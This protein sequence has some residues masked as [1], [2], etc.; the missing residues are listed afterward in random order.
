MN[1][2]WSGYFFSLLISIIF[3]PVT[4][5]QQ[6]FHKLYSVKDGL[7]QSQAFSI[8]QDDDGYIWI[9]TVGGGVNIYD[10]QSFHTYTTED[11]LA[12]NIVYSIIK[13]RQGNLWFGTDQGISKY[14]G[15]I[16][17]NY[18]ESDGLP[19]KYVKCLYFAEDQTL[20]IGTDKGCARMNNGIITPIKINETIDNSIILSIVEDN[21]KNIFFG[22]NGKGIIKYSENNIKEYVFPDKLKNKVW[23]LLKSN[24]GHIIFGTSNG[25][26][27]IDKDSI[28]T[29]KSYPTIMNSYIDDENNLWFISWLG[30]I[31]KYKFEN[32]IY[33]S[34]NNIGFKNFHFR[35]VIKDIEGNF[36]LGSEEGL[37]KFPP[38]KFINYNESD[39]LHY[40]NVFSITQTDKNEFWVSASTNGVSKMTIDTNGNPSFINYK[41][42]HDEDNSISSSSVYSVTKDNQGRLWFGT[43]GGVSIYDPVNNK[44][45][46]FTDEETNN[47]NFIYTPG[48]TNKVVSNILIAKNNIIWIG[49][50]NGVTKFTDSVFVNFNDKFPELE[51]KDII[52]IFEDKQ[53]NIWFTTKEGIYKYKG[54]QLTHYGEKDGFIDDIVNTIVQDDDNIY[55]LST[56]NGIFR[57]DGKQ[58]ININ[59]SDGLS[60]NNI[61]LLG[62]SKNKIYIGTNKGLDVLNTES[63]NRN[64]KIDLKHFGDLEGFMG[65]ECNRNA[66]MEDSEG[67]LWFGT[68]GGV[69]IF[70]PEKDFINQVLPK[71]FIKSIK[72]NF[73]DFDWT[74][75]CD[76]IDYKTNLP[77]N[78]ELPY[79]KNHISFR[80]IATSLTIPEKV[81][82]KYMLEG[83][84]EEWSPALSKTEVD[85]PALPPGEY[86]FK[87]KACNNDDVWN[88][89][90]VMFAF[91]IKPPFWR[92]TWFYILVGLTSIILI[93]L[94][95]KRREAKLK[96][97]KMVLEEKVVERTAEIVR[98]KEIV[99]QK[100][101]DITD[102]IN[103][104]KNIQEAILPGIVEFQKQFP[105]SFI[106]YHPRDIVSGDFYWMSNKENRTF[107]AASDCTGHGVPGAFM[108]ILGIAFLDDIVDSNPKISAAAL[109]NQLREYVKLSLHQTGKDGEQKDGMDM[110]L[111]IIDWTNK[112]LQFAAANNPLYLIRENELIEYKGDKMPVGFHIRQDSF[113]N[114]FIKIQPDDKIYLFSDGYAD[115]FGG[116]DNKKFKYKK[117]KELILDIHTTPMN[118]QKAIF[119]KT[120]KDWMGENH[121]IDDILVMGICIQ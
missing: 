120:I 103:Y 95:V 118:Q 9:G 46:N 44:F 85:Y 2:S 23:T 24:A 10:G 69:T 72:L 57:F 88:E 38:I 98:Q 42:Q 20:Y 4:Y 16:F 52:Y 79:N 5:G 74:P 48:L 82:Y 35:S 89:T 15:K 40:N 14:D 34:T 55:W 70:D 56:K 104:A 109:L 27:Y 6:Y 61:Y 111:G 47:K 91:T 19:N 22:T 7:S 119:E 114:N 41:Y 63:Y 112:E 84:D 11:G 78:L 81:K 113:T 33:K 117:L 28:Y 59:K 94:F 105:S 45:S 67:R 90:P 26:Y 49:T 80:Y 76:S 12:G 99:E 8:L 75:F 107:F 100:N 102:S 92:T 18:Y 73:M 53:S 65:Q 29:I 64:K 58:F 51:N 86:I 115:Q 43:W 25:L 21:E 50:V 39:S 108:S 77:Y 17:T 30:W 106:F 66:F 13:D 87:V 83:L 110:V 1:P 31:Y 121:Q 101:K 93:Y 96:K 97:E 116:A 54:K 37:I 62:Y 71:T 32:G 3:I 60:S 68:I 36:W